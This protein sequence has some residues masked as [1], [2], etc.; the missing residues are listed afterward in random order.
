MKKADIW[1]LGLTLYCLAFN[2]L[3]FEIGHSELEIMDNICNH[4]LKFEGRKI[5]YELKELL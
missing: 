2:I 4:E 1:S 5:S 3:P